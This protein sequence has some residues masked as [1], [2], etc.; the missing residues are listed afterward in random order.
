[1]ILCCL[2]LAACANTLIIN[3]C[4]YYYNKLHLKPFHFYLGMINPF[5]YPFIY[6][7]LQYW[8]K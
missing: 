1:M 8:N 6:E 2:S 3:N 5:K 4:I 7:L